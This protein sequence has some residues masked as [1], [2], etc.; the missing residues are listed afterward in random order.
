MEKA[1]SKEGKYH[2]RGQNRGGWCTI[3][4]LHAMEKGGSEE[5]KYDERGQHPIVSEIAL[6]PTHKSSDAMHVCRT[7]SSCLKGAAILLLDDASADVLAE[8]LLAAAIH[9]LRASL[10]LVRNGRPGEAHR[11]LARPLHVL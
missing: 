8:Q 9:D 4:G 3:V 6:P 2:Q 10:D 11:V 1:W 5:G 7:W